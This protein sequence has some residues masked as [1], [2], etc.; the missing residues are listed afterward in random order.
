MKVLNFFKQITW[1]ILITE[2]L[3]IQGNVFAETSFEIKT[4]AMHARMRLAHT[5]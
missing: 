3:N 5:A 1:I 4:A 2:K